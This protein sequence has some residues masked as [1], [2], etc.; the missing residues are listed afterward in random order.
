MEICIIVLLWSNFED[1]EHG[2]VG[3]K[4]GK[5]LAGMVSLDVAVEC[6]FVDEKCGKKRLTGTV[7]LD[8]AK[9][10]K[11]NMGHCSLLQANNP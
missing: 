6:G 10:L 2:F 8:V 1:T 7:S 9:A 3:E 4:C 11:C 5:R